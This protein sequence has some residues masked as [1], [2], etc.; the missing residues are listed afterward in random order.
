LAEAFDKEF[1]I[2]YHPSEFVSDLL[3]K[4]Y[5]L[6]LYDRFSERKYEICL[7]KKSKIS[8]TNFFAKEFLSSF[9]RK[10]GKNWD[11]ANK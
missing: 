4:I 3:F 2:F 9:R 6:G 5:L 11:R 8:T 7:E 1:K 10:L